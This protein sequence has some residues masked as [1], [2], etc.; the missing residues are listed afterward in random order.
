MNCFS[1]KAGSDPQEELDFYK[2]QNF[3]NLSTL[4]VIDRLNST[5]NDFNVYI[6]RINDHTQHLRV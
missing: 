2:Y 4:H 3:Q 1:E 6:S 5:L